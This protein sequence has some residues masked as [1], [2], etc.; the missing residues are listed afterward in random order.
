MRNSFKENC[1]GMVCSA[2][3]D[4]KYTNR[5]RIFSN[6]FFAIVSLGLTAAC[7]IFEVPYVFVTE[8]IN[9]YKHN[10]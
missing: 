5:V 8:I 3:S 6:V 9:E 7:V 2:L 10:S 4:Q 1:M